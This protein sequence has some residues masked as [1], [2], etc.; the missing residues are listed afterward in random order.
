[1]VVGLV[2]SVDLKYH[3]DR[4]RPTHQYSFRV[5]KVRKA[6]RYDAD[7]FM[8]HRLSTSVE[9]ERALGPRLG[10]TLDICVN[11]CAGSG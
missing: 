5:G 2:V 6:L 11:E 8:V 1:M 3:R 10:L 7:Y 4:T 9:R